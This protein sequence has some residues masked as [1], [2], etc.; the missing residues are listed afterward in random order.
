MTAQPSVGVCE[1]CHKQFPYW[2]IHNGFNDSAYAYCD[3]CEYSVTLS[4]WHR[5]IPAKAQLQIHKRISKDIE[6]FL[7]PCPCGGIFRADASP[8]FPHCRQSLSPIAAKTYIEANAPGTKKGW[9]WQDNW[10]DIY[11]VIMDGKSLT[12]WWRD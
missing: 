1:H 6:P 5:G 10:S 11:S 8:R 9:R 4:G 3:S 2:L 7:K 12:N